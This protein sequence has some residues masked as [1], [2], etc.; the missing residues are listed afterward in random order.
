MP[1]GTRYRLGEIFKTKL[2]VSRIRI[3]KRKALT[4]RQWHSTTV[5]FGG[6][7]TRRWRL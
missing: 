6:V 4:D 7:V 2:G 1:H 3:A 5:L